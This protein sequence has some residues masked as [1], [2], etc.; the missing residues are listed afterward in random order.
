MERA[1][2]CCASFTALV[3]HAWLVHG[4]AYTRTTCLAIDLVHQQQQLVKYMRLAWWFHLISCLRVAEFGKRHNPCCTVRC[5]CIPLHVTSYHSIATSFSLTGRLLGNIRNQGPVKRTV[6]RGRV[7]ARPAGMRLPP[8]MSPDGAAPAKVTSAVKATSEAKD[9]LKDDKQ[10]RNED[11]A[12]TE[13][14]VCDLIFRRH[15]DMG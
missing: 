14:K 6:I 5:S 12:K 15:F 2:L 3:V 1:K 13:D 7:G 10:E 4:C 11:A 8:P 9:N